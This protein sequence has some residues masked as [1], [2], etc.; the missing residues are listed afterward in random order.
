M[1]LSS[2][3]GEFGTFLIIIFRPSVEPTPMDAKDRTDVASENNRA[4]PLSLKMYE[5]DLIRCANCGDSNMLGLEKA[6]A[7]SPSFKDFMLWWCFDL[8]KLADGDKK[9]LADDS[10]A[11]LGS[12]AP[13]GTTLNF[14]PLGVVACDDGAF[15]GFCEFLA[16]L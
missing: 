12:A 6:R 11:F 5:P 1:Q 4:E 3:D 10:R 2:S 16:L 15:P 14:F 13:A 9:G 8:T 7:G